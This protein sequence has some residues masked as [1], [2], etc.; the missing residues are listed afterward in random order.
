VLGETLKF[1]EMLWEV[2]GLDF[3]EET[4]LVRMAEEL[5]FEEVREELVSAAVYTLKY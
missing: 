3:K 1:E 2:L 4:E 5:V